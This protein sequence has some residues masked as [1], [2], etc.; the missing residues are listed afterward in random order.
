MR[1]RALEYA[2]LAA[3]LMMASAGLYL[4]RPVA[5]QPPAANSAAPFRCVLPPGVTAA[6]AGCQP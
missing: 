1:P 5:A 4:I 6:E 2:V 3:F